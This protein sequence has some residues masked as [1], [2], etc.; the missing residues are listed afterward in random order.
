MGHEGQF[1]RLDAIADRQRT[2]PLIDALADRA[3]RRSGRF[4]VPGH[5]GR[6]IDPMLA[7]AWGDC[8]AWDLTELDGLDNWAAPQGAIA[9]AQTLAADC[10]GAAATR[11][12]VNGATGGITA[13]IA[14]VCGDG[15]ELIVARNAHQSVLSGLILSGARPVWVWPEVDRAWQLPTGV[16]PAAIAQALDAHP[17]AKG[18]VIV[19]PTYH[20]WVSDV[21]AIAAL[22]RSRRIPLIVDAAHG[23]HFGLHPALPESPLAAGADLVVASAHK[24]LGSLT[25]SALLHINYGAAID[26]SRLEQALRWV[27]SSSPSYLLMASLDGARRRAALSGFSDWAATLDRVDRVRS[28][29]GHDASLR[30]LAG[31]SLDRS[32]LT[33]HLPG[34][35]GYEV[36]EILDRDWGITAEL[37]SPHHVTFIWTPANSEAEGDRLVVALQAL[38]RSPQD[39]ALLPAWIGL[40]PP[41]SAPLTPREASQAPTEVVA[42]EQAIGR[43]AAESV[44]PY[45]PGIPAI[46]PGERVDQRAIEQLQQTLAL[47]GDCTG[48]ADPTLQTLRVVASASASP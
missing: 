33:V 6:A 27:T 42:I 41:S 36:D 9:A 44:C 24:T 23:A 30:V 43:I 21:R 39:P 7:D 45:P 22:T 4:H 48:C 8:W 25:Q 18:V 10:F 11:F 17:R 5:K 14:A 37:S 29:L 40:A 32:R 19:S 31:E 38:A 26:R 3:A 15:D 12:L 47:G 20:G 16:A 13:A 2:A 1:P 34:W 35:N 46:V 28:A